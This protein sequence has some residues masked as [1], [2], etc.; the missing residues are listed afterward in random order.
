MSLTTKF[1]CFECEMTLYTPSW[2]SDKWKQWYYFVALS[3][4]TSLFKTTPPPHG[5]SSQSQ[6]PRSPGCR[7]LWARLH[8]ANQRARRS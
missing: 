2:E 7:K 4:R 8:A 5:F 3:D 6:S 1:Q